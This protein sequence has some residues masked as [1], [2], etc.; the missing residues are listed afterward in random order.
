MKSGY[1][2]DTSVVISMAQGLTSVTTLELLPAGPTAISV[3]TEA[4]LRSGLNTVTG[5]ERL[6]RSAVLERLLAVY[7]PLP[8]TRAVAAAYGRVH[9][10]V[11]E[12][13]RKPRGRLADLLIAATCLAHD[14]TLLTHNSAD[15]VGLAPLI[16]VFH[17]VEESLSPA[18][19][20]APTEGG[21]SHR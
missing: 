1:L 3:V 4:E 18:P 16:D 10:A 19:D 21:A 6:A 17:A 9:L 8:V 13:G 7:D 11:I 12:A 20:K 15:F 5:Q 14:L 2:L